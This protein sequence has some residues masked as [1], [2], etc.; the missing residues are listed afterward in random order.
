MNIRLFTALRQRKLKRNKFFKNCFKIS[1]PHSFPLKKSLNNLQSASNT[2]EKL[3]VLFFASWK[4]FAFQHSKS[5]RKLKSILRWN[6]IQYEIKTQISI[7]F[8][9]IS[10]L[11]FY[12]VKFQIDPFLLQYFQN[13][14]KN[15]R[16][17]L[18]T[19]SNSPIDNIQQIADAVQKGL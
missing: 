14:D 10:V 9:Q 11:A 7:V 8:L 6:W 5:R 15:N 17:V 19:F 13:T 1:L 2:L 16:V 18:F 4:C 3:K 12:C